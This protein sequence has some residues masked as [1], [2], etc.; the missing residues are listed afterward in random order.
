M[1][2]V[3]LTKREIIKNTIEA[4]GATLET[5]LEAADT[6]AKAINSQFSILRLIGHFPVKDGDGVYSL[7]DKD[8]WDS[9]LA[10]RKANAKTAKS[11]K[12]PEEI[13]EQALER[14]RRAKRSL[15]YTSR[16]KGDGDIELFNLKHERT[17]LDEKIAIILLDNAR[18]AFGDADCFT[19]AEDGLEEIIYDDDVE[20]EL[21]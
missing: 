9:I 3:K 7:V 13:Y 20:E 19:M 1:S 10:E 5:L 8:T 2:E 16:V 18:A 17:V 4:G 12:T 6:T 15:V 21:I 11:E 14:L